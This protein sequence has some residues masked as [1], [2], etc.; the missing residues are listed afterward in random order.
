MQTDDVLDRIDQ[1]RTAIAAAKNPAERYD[2]VSLLT[3][4]LNLQLASLKYE[5][6]V[7]NRTRNTQVKPDVQHTTLP[8]TIS[9][10]GLVEEIEL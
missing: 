3:H 9:V 8:Q 5:K 2:A 1:A 7:F 10:S 4:S 6:S